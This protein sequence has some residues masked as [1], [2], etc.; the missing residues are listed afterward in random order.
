[1]IPILTA[2]EVRASERVAM[3]ELPPQ[4]L[5]DRA[6][7]AVAVECFHVFRQ[8]GGIVGRR[9]LLLVGSG[10]NGG[11]A[12]FAGARLLRRGVAVSAV[13]LGG[14]MH[15]QG[16]HAFTA[17]GGRIVS[18]PDAL[19]T[20][21]DLDLVIDGIVGIG[22]TR[23]LT[24][25]AALLARAIDDAEI[26]TLA[27]DVPSG[28][29]ADTGAIDGVAIDADITVTF[30]ALRPAH[31]VPPAALQCGEVLVA[32][33]GVEMQSHNA[34][35]TS[36]GGYFAPPSPDV[37]KYARGVVGVVTG[38]AQ[39]P[40]A[41]TLS[42][43]A[44][45]H[46]G[47]GMVR[48]FGPAAEHVVQAYPEVVPAER[49]AIAAAHRTQ[50][51]LVG[52]GFGTDDAA[53]AALVDVLT[54]VEPVVIDADALTVLSMR[55]EA[56]DALAQRSTRITILTPHVGEAARL[57]AG[58]GLQLDLDGDRIGAAHALARVTNSIVLLKG[59]STLISDGVHFLAT[60]LL[61]SQLATAGSGDVLA[62]LLA[63]ALARWSAAGPVSGETAMQLA[64]AA[65]IRH[66]A[67]ALDEDTTASDLVDSLQ[68]MR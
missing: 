66:A 29:N 42:V 27:I 49:A 30:G 53:V 3:A 19:A 5:M 51:W 45:L 65:A 31:V 16:L 32:D 8:S 22:S 12:L 37:D 9:V 56:R 50:A 23:P 24:G 15:T 20:F 26:F 54:K 67:A 7:T 11:D 63:G 21:G 10:D 25:D 55:E 44:A 60:P 13:S 17:A 47:C 68:Q 28:V 34:A 39:Y 52:C 48:Y 62:G 38:S 35:V 2:A 57:A 33:I 4:T 59:P 43:G 6:A 61:G 46:G 58:Y 64:A 18:V 40:G 36:Q 14:S 1:M 41:A